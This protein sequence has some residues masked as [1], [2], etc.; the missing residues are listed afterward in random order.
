MEN[1]RGKNGREKGKILEK[2]ERKEWGKIGEK[3]R[4]MGET[5]GKTKTGKWENRREKYLGIERLN[6]EGI[7]GILGEKMGKMKEKWEKYEGE[8]WG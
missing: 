6:P 3:L 2:T 4:K 8:K 5:M 1:S 7:S